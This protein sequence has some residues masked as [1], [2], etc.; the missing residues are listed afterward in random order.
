MNR[1]KKIILISAGTLSLA[2]GIVGIV[3][4]GLPT[5]TF[6][7]IASACYVR[8][9]EKLYSWLINHKV[10]GKFIRDYQTHKAITMRQKIISLVSMWLMITISA[11]FFINTMWLKI[12]LFLCAV[13]GSA[14]VLS[15]KTLKK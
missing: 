15:V 6:L 1:L 12:L 8:S 2:I 11:I 14:V 4:P 13:I 7:L 3:V 10:F 5:T 9:S